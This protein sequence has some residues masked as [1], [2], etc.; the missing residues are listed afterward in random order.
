MLV[1]PLLNKRGGGDGWCLAAR[2]NLLLESLGCCLPAHS[3]L[4]DPAASLRPLNVIS[5]GEPTESKLSFEVDLA[6]RQPWGMGGSRHLLEAEEQRLGVSCT[7]RERGCNFWLLLFYG[8]REEGSAS[9]V[10]R[11]GE[12]RHL[13]VIR[14]LNHVT[15][16]S[17]TDCSR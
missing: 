15:R 12:H 4:R 9:E 6:D 2:Q 1:F 10:G 14:I 8:L 7:S 16:Y 17:L 13:F 5:E 3:E 11:H